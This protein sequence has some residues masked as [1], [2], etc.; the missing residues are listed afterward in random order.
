MGAHIN[1]HIGPAHVLVKKVDGGGVNRFVENMREHIG[2][3][4][5]KR[6]RK[7]DG[8]KRISEIIDRGEIVGFVIDQLRPGEPRLPFI[9]VSAKTNTSLAAIWQRKPAPIIPAYIHRKRCGH[10]VF[11]VMPKFNLPVTDDPKQDII[12]HSILFNK[13]VEK[14]VRQYPYHYF[15]MHNR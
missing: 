12:N 2:F 15:W 3:R 7:D 14:A 6:Q 4:W 5:V 10:H 8:F 9:G 1:R 13:E 11:Q